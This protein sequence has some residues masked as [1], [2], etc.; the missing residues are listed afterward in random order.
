MDLQVDRVFT[1]ILV[2]PMFIMAV[3]QVA[4]W[5]VRTLLRKEPVVRD[6]DHPMMG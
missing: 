1:W 6:F 4:I 3:L 2:A 5:P